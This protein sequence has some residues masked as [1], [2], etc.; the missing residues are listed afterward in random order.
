MSYAVSN[1]DGDHL[2]FIVLSGGPDSGDC[3]VR[4]LPAERAHAE[5]PE[6]QPLLTLQSCGELY[7]ERV[8]DIVQIY[9]PEG[10]VAFSERDGRMTGYGFEYFVE[11][12]T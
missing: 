7:W 2:G 9:D 4:S 6:S 12:T 1:L 11:A 5:F 8:A 3:L 10:E